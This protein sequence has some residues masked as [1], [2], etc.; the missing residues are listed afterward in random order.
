VNGIYVMWRTPK[1]NGLETVCMVA[2]TPD[3]V[4]QVLRRLEEEKAL[5]ARAVHQDR[6][7]VPPHDYFD[8][9]VLFG[10][11]G[12]VGAIMFSDQTGSWATA[13]DGPEEEPIYA[14]I[15]FPPRCEI[16][17]GRVEAA[18]SEFLATHERP[19]CIDWQSVD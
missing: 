3:D 10:V 16:P 13:G 14:E 19:T 8:H 18:L 12:D 1:E 17:V 4:R 6:P 2:R 7:R 11:R 15:E 9:T 5:D